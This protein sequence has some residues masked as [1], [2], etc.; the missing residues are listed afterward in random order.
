MKK[1]I[2]VL[3]FL[4]GGVPTEEDRA[5]ADDIKGTVRFRNGKFV[6]ATDAA[7]ACDFIAGHITDDIAKAYAKAKRI[8]N[9]TFEVGADDAKIARQTERKA[10]AEAPKHGMRPPKAPPGS[11]AAPPAPPSPPGLPKA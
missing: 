6:A 5:I 1:S 11:A 10:R 8:E 3:Y 4:A 2:V 9:A 7:E